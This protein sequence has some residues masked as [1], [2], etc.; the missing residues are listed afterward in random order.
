[1]YLNYFIIKKKERGRKRNVCACSL[2]PHGWYGD[3]ATFN[4]LYICMHACVLLLQSCPTLWTPWSVA[5]QALL[6]T[7][8]SRQEYWSGFP[9]PPLRYLPNS[10][11]EPTS[12]VSSASQGDSLLL[13]TREAPYIH[14]CVYMCVCLCVY[15]CTYL[16]AL[17]VKNLPEMQETQAQSPG[18]GKIP[19]KRG[20]LPTQVFLPGEFHGQRNL[21]GY[22]PQ[23]CK[24][25]HMTEQLSLTQN[26]HIVYSMYILFKIIHGLT[27]RDKVTSSWRMEVQ[28]E[29]E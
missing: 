17:M 13:N 18:S 6:F 1:M 9:C 22:C 12:P 25:M 3:Y 29:R 24:E 19:W 14:V 28:K 11:T 27:M 10:G 16:V 23:G 26:L 2:F 15:V 8:F 7:G 4:I 20:W 21:E 5:C